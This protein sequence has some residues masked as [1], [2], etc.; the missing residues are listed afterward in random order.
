MTS[1]RYA[2]ETRSYCYE[3]IEVKLLNL[4]AFVSV[5][6]THGVCSDTS[7]GRHF[8]RNLN[9]RTTASFELTYRSTISTTNLSDVDDIHGQ[10]QGIMAHRIEMFPHG[11]GRL[12]FFHPE[13]RL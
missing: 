1:S 5:H 6:R 11:A 12:T 4:D 2:L 13:N 7:K 10:R 8:D 9:S 3:L